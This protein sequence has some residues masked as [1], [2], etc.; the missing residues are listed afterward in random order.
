MIAC[1]FKEKPS[2]LS[3]VAVSGNPDEADDVTLD[4]VSG[5]II[6]GAAF[7]KYAKAGALLR[8]ERRLDAYVAS[9]WRGGQVEQSPSVGDTYFLFGGADTR[10]QFNVFHGG[11]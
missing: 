11:R 1:P 10:G 2:R 6:E 3:I 9:A 8:S 7:L 4:G 5:M